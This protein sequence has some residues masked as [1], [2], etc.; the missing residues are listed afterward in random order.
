MCLLTVFSDNYAINRKGELL[1][2]G[3]TVFTAT[4]RLI[5]Q[6]CTPWRRGMEYVILGYT[7]L[8]LI[9]F[10][11]NKISLAEPGV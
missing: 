2:V 4:I 7:D 10:L 5:K 8:E 3:F 11:T 1:S 6:A 9:I